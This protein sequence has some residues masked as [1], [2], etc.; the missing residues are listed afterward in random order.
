[1]ESKMREDEERA[2]ESFDRYLFN[3]RELKA[4]WKPKPN[5]KNKAPDYFMWVG[6]KKFAVEVTALWGKIN[7]GLGPKP[8]AHFFSVLDCFCHRIKELA[9]EKDYLCGYY[10][11]CLLGNT[12]YFLQDKEDLETRILDYI[13]KT[14]YKNQTNFE[15]ILRETGC[16]YTICKQTNNKND[17][18]FRPSLAAWSGSPEVKKETC[19]ILH[20]RISK[21]K[22]LLK[23]IKLPKI[24]LLPDCH[25]F[26]NRR[27][28]KECLSKINSFDFFH[29][30]F[31]TEGYNGYFIYTIEKRWENT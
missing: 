16:R 12:K 14:K 20:D 15:P 19:E 24:L 5:G 28:Y 23:H 4:R 29:S 30:I 13:R 1:M 10:Y 18:F 7:A 22:K 26:A 9:L 31:V 21:K 2:K 11:I 8:R 17:I 25:G 3:E 27:T 6:N